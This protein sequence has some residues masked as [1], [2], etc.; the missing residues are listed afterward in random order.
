MARK[1]NV[2]GTSDFLVVAVAL[3]GLGLWCAKD[4]WF[5]SE[6][7]ME[8]HPLEVQLKVD[9]P[10]LVKDVFVKPNDHVREDQPVARILRTTT[11]GEQMIKTPIQGY[12]TTLHVQRNDLVNRDQV[13]A[14][15]TPEDTYY[16]FNKSLAVLALLG[17]LICAI[18]HLLVR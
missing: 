2:P 18:I 14:L 4:G 15:M 17:A 12:I 11:N 10:G 13:V 1:F 9:L 8:K 5:P 6:A 16:S 7:T 3:L